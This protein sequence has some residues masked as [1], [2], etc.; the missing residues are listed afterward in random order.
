M[1]GKCLVAVNTS[2][3]L[4]IALFC[5]FDA[6]ENK[7]RLPRRECDL[8]KTRSIIFSRHCRNDHSI[9]RIVAV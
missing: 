9:R 6:V 1:S 8:S 4:S 2:S 5:A 7:H 3:Q